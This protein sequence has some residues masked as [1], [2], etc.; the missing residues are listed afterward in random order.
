[1]NIAKIKILRLEF[2]LEDH[3]TYN[4]DGYVDS[5]ILHT[6]QLRLKYGI[7]VEKIEIP[8]HWDFSDPLG[9]YY[10]HGDDHHIFYLRSSLWMN[11]FNRAHEETHTLQCLGKLDLL[12]DKLRDEQRR[13]LDLWGLRNDEVRAYIFLLKFK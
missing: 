10:M 3:Q 9:R 4:D 6:A 5:V 7:P 1:M 12:E 11:I 13:N 8:S 2:P